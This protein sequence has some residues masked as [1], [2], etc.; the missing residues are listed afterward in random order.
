MS[1]WKKTLTAPAVTM[2]VF[3]LAVGLL[4]FS[5]VG[6]ARA[7]LT[8]YSENYTT[9]VQVYDI[10]VSL[11]ENGQAVAG[12][13]DGTGTLLTDL[14]PEGESLK[15][16]VTYP[17]VLTVQNTGT[18]DQY[19]R[20]NLY[21][22]WTDADG[23]KVQNL[24]PDLID[25]ALDNLDS[26][27]LVDEDASTPERTVLYYNKVLTVGE[28]SPALTQSLTI[29]S[30]VGTKV[31][32]STTTTEDGY[33]TITTVY[34]YDGYRFNVEAKV[35]AVQEH[36]AEDAIWSAWGRQVSVTDGSLSLN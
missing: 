1:N 13:Y 12:Q 17:E 23:N 32:Q 8:Y 14:L 30:M 6:G 5:T 10:G 31:T 28:V 2:V 16:G 25:L 22:Y 4:L 18:I 11:Q 35:D 33:T 3:L 21:K 7:A 19:V 34:D 9:R 24:S 26:D 29:S 27:W 36:N 15:L 20:V